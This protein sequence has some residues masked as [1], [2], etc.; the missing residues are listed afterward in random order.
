MSTILIKNATVVSECSQKQPSS[1][2]LPQQQPPNI[3]PAAKVKNPCGAMRPQCSQHGVQ[4]VVMK[5][6]CHGASIPWAAR[7]YL[8][9][10]RI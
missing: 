4:P 5:G 8:D 3:T 2:I 1:K 7:L 10:I 6:G 9:H